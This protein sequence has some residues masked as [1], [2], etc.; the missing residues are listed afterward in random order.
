MNPLAAAAC[1]RAL[2]SKRQWLR[3]AFRELIKSSAE[4]ETVGCQ[5]PMIARSRH[6]IERAACELASEITERT[7]DAESVS[8]NRA[9][10]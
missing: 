7:R 3:N 2:D 8:E 1:L 10:V 6:T 9:W 4:G 5:F